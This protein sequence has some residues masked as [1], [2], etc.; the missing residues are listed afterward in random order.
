METVGHKPPFKTHYPRLTTPINCPLKSDEYRLRLQ[1]YA[2]QL[3]HALLN[4]VF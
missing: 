3:F 2:P 1:P 4:M